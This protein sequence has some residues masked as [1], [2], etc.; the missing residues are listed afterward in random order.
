MRF[1]RW[2]ICRV[3]L[4][5]GIVLELS[6]MSWG[7][8]FSAPVLDG[9]VPFGGEKS[10]NATHGAPSLLLGT[11]WW[12]GPLSFG[13]QLSTTNGFCGPTTME[14]GTQCLSSNIADSGSGGTEVT[15]GDL[16]LGNP[17]FLASNGSLA[18]NVGILT[19]AGNFSVAQIG[20]GALTLIGSSSQ[21]Q[22]SNAGQLQSGSSGISVSGPLEN[23][24]NGSSLSVGAGSTL[25]LNS[26]VSVPA[27]NPL[28]TTAS[29]SV[30]YLSG[31]STST[32][33]TVGGGGMLIAAASPDVPNGTCLNVGAGA[34]LILDS[35][36]VSPLTATPAVVIGSPIIAVPEPSTLVLLVIAAGSACFLRRRSS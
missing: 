21:L 20:T 6:G 17:A 8:T 24:E 3:L 31:S 19:T 16:V 34:T 7:S 27:V 11:D 32:D 30:I 36:A 26:T 25:I 29:G 2:P 33:T 22:L 1:L 18:G 9:P 13:P 12:G 10:T 5:F 35:K 28:S 15:G 23:W 14:G 4:G